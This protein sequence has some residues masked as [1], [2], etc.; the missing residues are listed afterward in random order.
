MKVNDAIKEF[1]VGDAKDAGNVWVVSVKYKDKVVMT[2]LLAKLNTATSDDAVKSVQ[3]SIGKGWKAGEPKLFQFI[4]NV[5]IID[6]RGN[7]V[8]NIRVDGRS[9]DITAR[10]PLLRR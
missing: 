10:L 4:Y 1:K 7:A 5:P 6:S 9:G 8:G 3:D 2:I